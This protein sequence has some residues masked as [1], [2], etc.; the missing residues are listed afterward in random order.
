MDVM[1][2]FRRPKVYVTRRIPQK[3]VDVLLRDCDVSMWDSENTVVR[4]ELLYNVAGVDAILCM[5]N[6]IIDSV[7]LDAA[8][9]NLK[10]VATMCNSLDDID[11]EACNKSGI[12]VLSCPNLCS[13]GKADLTV[14]LMLLT[15]KRAATDPRNLTV[16]YSVT[17]SAC[18]EKCANQIFGIY[19]LNT[20]GETI[21]KRLKEVGVNSIIA[22]DSNSNKLWNN[23]E[24]SV[25]V[26][27]FADLLT[28]SDVLCICDQNA[29][30]SNTRFNKD[31]FKQMKTNAVIVVGENGLSE[32]LDYI[33]LYEALRD[34]KFL[35]A[36]INSCNQGPVPFQYPLS[37]LHNCVFLPQTQ[38]SAFDVRHKTS[39]AVAS[40]LLTELKYVQAS[41]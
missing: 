25:K 33:S 28:Q 39:V 37:G 29:D 1:S 11:V 2:L 21:A 3:G 23:V 24:S 19:G 38:E 12:R 7:V 6:D 27:D 13:E 41:N 30:K 18:W 9:S 5:A 34:G 15:L 8:G 20:T 31:A 22:F 17:N 35:A 36:G 40:R 32:N 26:V 14:S 4:G 10:V 16:G